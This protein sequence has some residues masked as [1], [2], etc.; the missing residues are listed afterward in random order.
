ME[1]HEDL[2]VIYEYGSAAKYPQMP[3]ENR[4][5]IAE[6]LC[7]VLDYVHAAGHACG[8]L[9]PKNISVDPNTGPVVFLDTASYHIPNGADFYRCDVGIPEYLPVE[10]QM[11]MRGGGTLATAELPTFS[12]ETDNFALAIHIFQLLMNSVHPFACAILPNQPSV[13]APQLSDSIIKGEFPFMQNLPGIVIPSYAPPITILPQALQ[14]LFKRA[15][16]DG[17]SNPGLRPKSVEWHAA[18]RALRN[19]LII[20]SKVPHHQYYK[21]LSSC[22]W[23]DVD[24]KFAQQFKPRTILAQTTIKTP[25]VTAPAYTPQSGAAK[26]S[27][28]P[29]ATTRGGQ[30]RLEKRIIVSDPQF[31]SKNHFPFLTM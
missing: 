21:S 4:L 16:I 12:Q 13:V 17:H 24:S 27:T 9:N 20:C 25:M 30:R 5:I 31:M 23:C 11:K 14:D 1:I 2:N 26:A 6:N 3:W 8:D 18:L 15:F 19:E 29:S 10:I 28:S 7:A 22:P